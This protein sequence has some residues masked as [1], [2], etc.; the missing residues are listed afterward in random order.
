MTWFKLLD[1]FIILNNIWRPNL[2]GVDIDM[3]PIV[4]RFNNTCF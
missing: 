4:P 2:S 3:I 1:G